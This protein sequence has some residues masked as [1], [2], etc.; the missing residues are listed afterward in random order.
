MK[1]TRLI[2][3]GATGSIGRQTIDCVERANAA[4]PG[5]F[6]VAGLSA[7]RNAEALAAEGRRF[8]GAALAL[9][10]A[11]AGDESFR[12]AGPGASIG[13]LRE[14]EADLVVNGIAGAAGLLASI[15]ALSA[16]DN[17]ALANKESVVMGYSHLAA[18]AAERGLAIIPVDSEHAA[19]FQLVRRIGK[20][21]VSELTI[22]ASGGPFRSRSLGELERI[23]PDEAAHHPVWN[24]GR[25]IS[26]DSATLANKGLELIEAVRLFGM[27]EERVKVLIHPESLVHALVRTV[28]S[29]LYAHV[30]AP[31]MRLPINIA[32]NWPEEVAADF[33]VLDLAGKTLHFE[34]PDTARFPML[35]L[36]RRAVRVGEAATIAYNA[37]DEI[38]VQAFEEGR[39]RFTQIA[40]VVARALEADWALPV[41]DVG[42]IFDHDAR[43]RGL[44]K[45][46]VSEYEC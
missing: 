18:L 17:L 34:E 20:S 44:A 6:V 26:I 40:A 36:A 1:S 15:E 8:P 23:S 16:G 7:G 41:P 9:D 24:M 2:I 10:A 22:T 19:L 28:D 33:G 14:T 45:L 4:E 31:D 42:S 25:K 5:R 37:A 3:L 12:F 39:L 32:L 30:S 21:S 13:L 27:P 46:A 38:A 29:A 11:T 43:A 35:D